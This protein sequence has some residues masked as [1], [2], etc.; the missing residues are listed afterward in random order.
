MDSSRFDT[1]TRILTAQAAH[2]SSRRALVPLLG[3]LAAGLGQ[4][5]ATEAKKRKKRNKRKPPTTCRAGQTTDF[6][7]GTDVVCTTGS[8]EAGQC[9]TTTGGAPY[10]AASG[11]CFECATNADCV[12]VCGQGAACVQCDVGCPET[13]GTGCLGVSSASCS[14]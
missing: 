4:R 7:G 10:C 6:C 11:N 9:H 12:E 3:G 14:I 5:S 1:L 2:R 13:G 8:G